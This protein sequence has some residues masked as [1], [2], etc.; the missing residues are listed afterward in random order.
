MLKIFDTWTKLVGFQLP[1][2]SS[3]FENSNTN[4]YSESP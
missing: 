3:G 2:M 4:F 1:G